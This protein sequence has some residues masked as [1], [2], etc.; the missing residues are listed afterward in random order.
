[1][2]ANKMDHP[3]QGISCEVSNCRYYMT[4]NFCSADRIHV[5]PRHA[6]TSQETD[7]STFAPA[8][9]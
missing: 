8:A 5:T 2:K 7:C 1:M 6:S 9:Q 4:G 3:N